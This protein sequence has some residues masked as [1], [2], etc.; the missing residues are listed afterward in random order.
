VEFRQGALEARLFSQGEK[1]V[2]DNFVI[3]KEKETGGDYAGSNVGAMFAASQALPVAGRGEKKGR[4]RIQWDQSR[5][6]R[7]LRPQKSCRR[8]LHPLDQVVERKKKK[9][10]AA[11]KIAHFV[12]GK[13]RR[14]SRKNKETRGTLRP[15]AAIA[16]NRREGG[17]RRDPAL[18]R[19][20]PSPGFIQPAQKREKRFL[21]FGFTLGGKKVKRPFRHKTKSLPRKVHQRGKE[22][23]LMVSIT[24]FSVHNPISAEE[25]LGLPRGCLGPSTPRVST[26]GKGKKKERKNVAFPLARCRRKKGKKKGG[27]SV[28]DA[29]A[30][31]LRKSFTSEGGKRREA[32]SLSRRKRKRKESSISSYSSWASI[33]CKRKEK[34]KGGRRERHHFGRRK[35]RE[36][37]PKHGRSSWIWGGEKKKRQKICRQSKGCRPERGK[38]GRGTRGQLVRAVFRPSPISGCRAVGKKRKEETM[39]FELRRRQ[40]SNS[41]GERGGRGHC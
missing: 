8:D 31:G 33:I 41:R 14:R 16:P 32:A 39:D 13:G 37:G 27:A 3:E 29:S 35:K 23:V 1:K 11:G 17:K 21:A 5:K 38:K 26:K 6:R 30:P 15:S 4:L 36:K 24:N 28:F 40:Y 22:K 7:G 19:P 25:R 9:G 12:E 18:L 2:G 10:R 20:G 34:K